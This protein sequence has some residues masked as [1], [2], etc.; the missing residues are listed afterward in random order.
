MTKWSL[1]GFI[2]LLNL[3]QIFT[4]IQ[5]L[6]VDFSVSPCSSAPSLSPAV[7]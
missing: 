2:K 4:A 1:E 5:L 7:M 3:K 6:N